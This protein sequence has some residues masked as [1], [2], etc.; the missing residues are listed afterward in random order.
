MKGI[1]NIIKGALYFAI[2]LSVGILPKGKFKKAIRYLIV[3]LIKEAPLR[4][5]MGKGDT[6][7]QVG[8]VVKGDVFLMAKI[9]GPSGRVVAVEPHPDNIKAIQDRL[10][11]ESINNVILVAKGAWS[12]KGKQTLLIHPDNWACSRIEI[13]GIKHD[14]GLRANEYSRAVEIEVDTLDNILAG[15]N[16]PTVDFIKITVMGAELEVLKG[17]DKALQG[18]LQLW[19]KGHALKYG[20]PTNKY[21]ATML[22]DRGFKAVITKGTVTSDGLARAGDVYAVR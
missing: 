3:R 10:R 7:V 9:V 18:N 13:D 8:A 15:L 5:T 16:I 2:G 11:E 14:R 1:L 22:R 19:S 21:I 6:V 4:I 17:M 12:K 20:Q